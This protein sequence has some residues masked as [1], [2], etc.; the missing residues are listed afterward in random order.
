MKNIK[1]ELGG[2]D[3]S[4]EKKELMEKARNMKWPE[5]V[6]KTFNKEWDKLDM[7]NPQSPEYSV[8][9]NYLQQMVSLP[10]GIYTTDNLDLNRAKKKLDQDHYGME[11]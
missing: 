1:E 6:A 9:Y 10:W 7:F 5:E 11:K 4:P 2:S 8:Q 3:G